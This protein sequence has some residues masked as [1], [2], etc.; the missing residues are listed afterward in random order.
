[1]VKRRLSTAVRSEAEPEVEGSGQS[2]AKC[3]G[4]RLLYVARELVLVDVQV[5]ELTCE[6]AHAV[7]HR[8]EGLTAVPAQRHPHGRRALAQI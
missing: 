2:G 1:M 7:V 5:G 8:V 6:V 3:G 4:S